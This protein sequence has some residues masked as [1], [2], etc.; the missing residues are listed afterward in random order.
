MLFNGGLAAFLSKDFSTAVTLWKRLKE[1]EPDE[2]QARA[3][4]VQAYQALNDLK[5]RDDERTALFELR[6]SGKNKELSTQKFYCR[7]QMEIAGRKV[8]VF[9]HYELVGNRALRYAFSVANES[10]DSAEYEITFGSYETT[11]AIWRE[12]ANPKPKEGQRLF[13]L[14]GYFKGG[15]A[16]YGFYTPGPSY[17]D[18]RK[19]VIGI[20]EG[21]GKPISS[22]T[23][24]RPEN[25][26]ENS[27]E[28][29]PQPEQKK[30]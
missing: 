1:V 13:H 9:E 12:T 19:I 5:A 25:K 23:I 18:I 7:E 28:K 3:K 29:K 2:W 20:I 27:T 17:D 21:K 15:H 11:N 24:S 4:L 26:K 14:D 6:K 8:Y 30:P 10:G 16:T 22:T